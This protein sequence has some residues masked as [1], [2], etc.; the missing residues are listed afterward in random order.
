MRISLKKRNGK[1]IDAVELRDDCT[2]DEFKE[3]FYKKCTYLTLQIFCISH[4]SVC[5]SPEKQARCK[6]NL[7]TKESLQKFLMTPVAY[8]KRS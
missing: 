8:H 2:V 3:L 6:S 7:E 4:S 1:F 5:V